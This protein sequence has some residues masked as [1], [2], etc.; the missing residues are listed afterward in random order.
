MQR[1][2][3]VILTSKEPN[4]L[5]IQ[6]ITISLSTFSANCL[7]KSTFTVVI[8]VKRIEYNEAWKKEESKFKKR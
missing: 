4:L 8:A 2:I 1:T 5:I 6:I 7:A 3:K